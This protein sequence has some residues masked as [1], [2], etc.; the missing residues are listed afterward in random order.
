LNATLWKNLNYGGYDFRLAI[1]YHLGVDDVDL[2][3]IPYI[4]NLDEDD[5]P[6]VLG[7]GWE[8]KDIRIANVTSDNYLRIYNGTGFEDIL[9]NQTLDRSFTDMDDNT[10]I[11]FVCMNPSTYHLSRDLYLSWNRNL[12]YKVTVMLKVGQVSIMPLCHCLSALEH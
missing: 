5:I 1:R 2:T 3:V 7:F 10:T 12:T 11:R 9:L 4:K 6:Y 8:M